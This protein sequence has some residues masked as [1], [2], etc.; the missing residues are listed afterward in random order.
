MK[1][2]VQ[3]VR[4]FMEDNR[5]ARMDAYAAQSAFYIIMGLIP[6]VMLLLILIQ[7]TPLTEEDLLNALHDALPEAFWS[8]LEDLVRGIF[9][10]NTAILS[11]TAIAAL[12]AC[13]RSVMSISNGL[14]SIYGLKETRNYILCRIRGVF[15]VM[16][17]LV[18]LLLALGMLVFGNTIHSILLVY[19]PALT[20]ISDL[21]ILVRTGGVLVALMLLIAAMY[22]YLPNIR[23]KFVTQLPGAALAAISWSV[24]SYV[25]SLYVGWKE[26]FTSIYGGLTMIVMIMLWLYFCMW[27]LFAGAQ[28]NRFYERAKIKN[29]L[30]KGMKI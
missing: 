22:T 9:V 13:G 20:R 6:F 3:T 29:M 28:F 12:W 19:I 24:F 2:A 30:D 21:I 15:Y 17:L 23:R 4:Q 18:S 5:E 14:N 26:K 8:Y 1:K 27:L 7:Y 10:K 16:I 11:G 25:I